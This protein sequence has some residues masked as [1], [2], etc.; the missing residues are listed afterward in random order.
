MGMPDYIYYLPKDRF[1]CFPEHFNERTIGTY[2]VSRFILYT[3]RFIEQMRKEIVKKISI[4]FFGF[5]IVL[6]GGQWTVLSVEGGIH[7]VVNHFKSQADLTKSKEVRL[8]NLKAE[9]QQLVDDHNNQ[10][11]DDATFAQRVNE[12]KETEK[13]IN[14]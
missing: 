9:A 10:K 12:L 7:S 5:S 8:A 6:A 3:N 13:Q 4:V 1:V 14:Q 2:N 11:I